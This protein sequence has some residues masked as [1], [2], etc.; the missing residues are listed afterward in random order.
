M[1]ADPDPKMSRVQMPQR[2]TSSPTACTITIAGELLNLG[3][4]GSP[5]FCYFEDPIVL[6]HQGTSQSKEI[7]GTGS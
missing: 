4:F 7:S 5:S 1:V 6:T 3:V 2:V